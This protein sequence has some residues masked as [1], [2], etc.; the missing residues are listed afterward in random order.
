MYNKR[1]SEIPGS[2]CRI[3]P[4]VNKD[5]V[6]LIY[7]IVGVDESLWERRPRYVTML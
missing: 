7:R 5:D 2:R 6:V 1:L 4:K 3:A